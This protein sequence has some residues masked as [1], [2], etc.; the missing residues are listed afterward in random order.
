MVPTSTGPIF[1]QNRDWNQS[2]RSARHSV[3]QRDEKDKEMNE[4]FNAYCSDAWTKGGKS[5]ISK[6]HHYHDYIIIAGV[7]SDT[8]SASS[9]VEP[10]QMW[11]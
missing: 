6:T 5:I 9:Q 4:L 8:S 2:Q 7:I 11:I 10:W 1:M 3:G